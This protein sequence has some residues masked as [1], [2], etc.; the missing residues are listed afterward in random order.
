MTHRT[1]LDCGRDPVSD[2]WTIALW[3]ATAELLFCGYHYRE[4]GAYDAGGRWRR[5]HIRHCLA[6]T[7][8]NLARATAM[9]A[10]FCG[11]MRQCAKAY[12][13]G[14]PRSSHLRCSF[15][16]GFAD[17][18]VDRLRAALAEARRDPEVDG[19]YARERASNDAR[20]RA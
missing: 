3:R 9:A 19:A 16:S 18:L 17:R 4:E 7:P 15:E 6:G 20:S 8:A 5:R 11:T 2:R 12:A 1:L 10:H 14:R 13:R